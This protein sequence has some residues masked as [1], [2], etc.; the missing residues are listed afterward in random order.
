MRLALFKLLVATAMTSVSAC[1]PL[2]TSSDVTE[3]AQATQAPARAQL[4][5]SH[6][7]PAERIAPRG[8]HQADIIQTT[9]LAGNADQLSQNPAQY[10]SGWKTYGPL[11][12][13]LA[14]IG[15]IAVRRHQARRS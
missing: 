15:A 9:A 5:A 12:V 6:P 4:V 2:P 13:T 14:L 1:T 11:G 7:G 3:A 8:P 10:D